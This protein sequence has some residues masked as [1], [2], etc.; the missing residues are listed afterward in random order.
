MHMVGAVTPLSLLALTQ[1]ITRI[2][3]A[4]L[5]SFQS[6]WFKA[7]GRARTGHSDGPSAWA[8]NFASVERRTGQLVGTPEH[9]P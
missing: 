4:D 8:R 1:Q 9:A 5:S 3:T 7:A 6:S 2:S